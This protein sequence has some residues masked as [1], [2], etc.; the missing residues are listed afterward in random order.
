VTDPLNDDPDLIAELRGIRQEGSRIGSELEN[1]KASQTEVR[2]ILHRVTG[3]MWAKMVTI[4]LLVVAVSM[5]TWLFF[6]ERQDRER[7]RLQDAQALVATQLIILSAS[8]QTEVQRLTTEIRVGQQTGQAQS[9]E[10]RQQRLAEVSG[11]L[12]QID[13]NLEDLQAGRAPRNDVPTELITQ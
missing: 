2:R 7:E 4:A 10:V 6:Q 8:Y 9:L 1:V 11:V 13:E 3:L 12:K 5:L